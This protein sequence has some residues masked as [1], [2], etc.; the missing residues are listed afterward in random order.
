MKKRLADK[1]VKAIKKTKHN[2]KRKPYTEVTE[3]MPSKATALALLDGLAP[4]SDTARMT[5]W[6]LEG[7]TAATRWLGIEKLVHPVAFDGKVL[8]FAGERPRVYAWAGIESL[9]IKYEPSASLLTLKF[10]TFMAGSGAPHF[11]PRLVAYSRGEAPTLPSE[12]EHLMDAL[13]HARDVGL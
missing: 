13:A 7:D 12:H 1:S 6:L 9:E 3:G 5:R 8:C 10:R 2:D 4:K 11:A